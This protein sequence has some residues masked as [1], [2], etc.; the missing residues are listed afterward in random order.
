MSDPRLSIGPARFPRTA[1]IGVA[2]TA[3]LILV[4]MTRLGGKPHAPHLGLLAAAPI[5]IQICSVK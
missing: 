5:Q 2:V 4:M 1:L 3:G